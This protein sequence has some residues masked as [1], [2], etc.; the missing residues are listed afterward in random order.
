MSKHS[1]RALHELAEHRRAEETLREAEE[2][3]RSAFS[4]AA[5]GVESAEQLAQ[6]RGLGCDLAQGNYFSEPL[7]A[8]AAPALLASD[9]Y[10]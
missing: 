8:E 10:L 2:R 7:P 4:Y 1:E 5:E 9:P 3:F 6:L